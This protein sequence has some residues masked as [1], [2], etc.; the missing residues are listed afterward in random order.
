MIKTSL[1]KST[2]IFFEINTIQTVGRERAS[3]NDIS[4][5]LEKY[6]KTSLLSLDLNYIQSEVEKVAWIK[7]VIIRR[8][9][10]STFCLLYTSPSPRDRT[11]SRMP[12]SA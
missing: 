3:R 2:E 1:I 9:L 6:Q 10:P 7:K 4:K 12:S 5:I 8:V 11:R